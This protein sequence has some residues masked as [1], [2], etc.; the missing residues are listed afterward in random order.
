[1]PPPANFI[2]I[3]LPKERKI[4]QSAWFWR[5]VPWRGREP[6]SEKACSS[7]LDPWLNLAPPSRFA[8]WPIFTHIVAWTTR[9]TPH[10]SL[11]SIYPEYSLI[12]PLYSIPQMFI[13]FSSG[14]SSCHHEA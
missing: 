14:A 12:P 9:S 5:G 7:L 4:C 6:P 11:T 3:M 13:P 10:G 2:W 1:M 8:F